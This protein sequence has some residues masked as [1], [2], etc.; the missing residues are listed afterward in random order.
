MEEETQIIHTNWGIACRI[1]D[2]IYINKKLLNYPQLHERILKHELDHSSGYYL[3][4]ILMDLRNN[5]LKGLKKQYYKFI[6]KNPK[7]LS[8][9]LPF[10][11]YNKKIVVSPLLLLFYGLILVL[12]EL[13]WIII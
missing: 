8:E 9:F 12:G 1:K 10:W 2:D 7:S 3:R 13:L 5:H 6:L 4:D 11:F